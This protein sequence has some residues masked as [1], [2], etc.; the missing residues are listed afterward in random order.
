[1]PNKV[2]IA[3][4][5]GEILIN[6][7]SRISRKGTF[8]RAIFSGQS[9]LAQLHYISQTAGEKKEDLGES[10]V[11]LN[12]TIAAANDLYGSPTTFKALDRKEPD[13]DEKYAKRRS[14]FPKNMQSWWT[15]Q[16]LKDAPRI[17]A[18]KDKGLLDT[19]DGLTRGT[20]KWNFVYSKLDQ[21]EKDKLHGD[22]NKENMLKVVKSLKNSRYDAL[23]TIWKERWGK[24]T[25][26]HHITP[27]NFNGRNSVKNFI[28]LKAEKHVGS[29][30]VH[31]QFWVPLKKFLMNI[32]K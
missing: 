12:Y 24:S 31:P 5:S 15:D 27:I 10:K 25:H 18:L 6:N 21:V 17:Q 16:P 23:E 28:P 19:D 8:N 30:G 29:D 2:N 13:E 26:I 32:R 7:Y 14:A 22:I 3:S 9:T 20:Y 1:M 11:N 4:S